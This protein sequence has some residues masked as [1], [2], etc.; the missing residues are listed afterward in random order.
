M[1][2]RISEHNCVVCGSK[3]T[4]PLIDADY[5]GIADAKVNEYVNALQVIEAELSAAKIAFLEAEK[6]YQQYIRERTELDSAIA[7][8]YTKL[9]ELTHRLPPA[10]AERV[11]KRDDLGMLRKSIETMQLELETKRSA[12]KKFIQ[13]EA[14]SLVAKAQDIQTTFNIY[15]KGF[16]FEEC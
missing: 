4:S 10:E 1:E 8:R 6:E 13:D 7:N 9:D 3:L 5:A 14:H 16:L 15:A 2:S 12:F 11:K